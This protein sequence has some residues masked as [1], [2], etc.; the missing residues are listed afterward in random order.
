MRRTIARI[1]DGSIGERDVGGC[2]WDAV[3]ESRARAQVIND[4]SPVGRN[5]AIAS[6]WDSR[7]K[8]RDIAIISRETDESLAEER[9]E[10]DD[11][12]IDC[13]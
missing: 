1:E 7:E 6:R 11:L 9:V 8:N 12:L 13:N 4:S 10:G 3:G 5:V 2:Q